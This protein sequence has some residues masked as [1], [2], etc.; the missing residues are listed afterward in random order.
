MACRFGLRSYVGSG[1][2]DN[3]SQDEPVVVPRCAFE[4]LPTRSGFFCKRHPKALARPPRRVVVG[5]KKRILFGFIGFHVWE[6]VTTKFLQLSKGRDAQR[7]HG[8]I[9]GN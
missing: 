4:K 2:C 1:L 3:Y 6:H 7:Q 5:G 9:T 8:K